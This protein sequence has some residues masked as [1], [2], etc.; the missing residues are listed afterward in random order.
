MAVLWAAVAQADICLG[1][2]L[3][4]RLALGT[5]LLLVLAVRGILMAAHLELMVTP[6]L[7]IVPAQLA[8]GVE[9]VLQAGKHQIAAVQVAAVCH[10]TFNPQAVREQAG[11]VTQAVQ[12]VRQP[13]QR[14]QVE[15]AA[16]K[17]RRVQPPPVTQHPVLVAMA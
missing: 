14:A 9:A 3:Y 12:A 10:L 8:V 1:L 2:Q 4:F 13:E 6:Q 5:Q 16:V 7:L 17:M 11:K 15:A